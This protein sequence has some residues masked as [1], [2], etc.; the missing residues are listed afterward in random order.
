MGEVIVSSAAI[1]V[2]AV[3]RGGTILVRQIPV[4]LQASEAC[5]IALAQVEEV[6]ALHPAVH[7]SGQKVQLA[8][9]Y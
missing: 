5:A 8:P 6:A 9:G 1:V 3:E 7:A 2:S 4:E